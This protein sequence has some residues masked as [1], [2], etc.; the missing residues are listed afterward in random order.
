MKKYPHWMPELA[1]GRSVAIRSVRKAALPGWGLPRSRTSPLPTES[2][3]KAKCGPVRGLRV[4]GWQPGLEP[5]P[6][7][8]RAAP[9]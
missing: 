1:L 2:S 4:F 6:R 9:C 3:R 5:P 8:P 7:T